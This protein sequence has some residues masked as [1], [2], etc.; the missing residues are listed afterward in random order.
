MLKVGADEVLLSEDEVLLAS[1]G[2]TIE[3]DSKIE[4]LLV[5]VV[6]DVVVEITT[7]GKVSIGSLGVLVVDDVDATVEDSED[8]LAVVDSDAWLLELEV[9][10]GTSDD[11]D[12]LL[13]VEVAEMLAGTLAV[14]YG[15]DGSGTVPL[16]AAGAP[17][18]QIPL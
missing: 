16:G 14:G 11:V 1:I 3:D 15:P 4:E 13:A 12:S 6:L 18:T 17:P 5:L 9:T 7:G 2:L 8:V 10:G